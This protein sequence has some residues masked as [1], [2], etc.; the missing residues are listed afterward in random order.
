MKR[1]TVKGSVE[2]KVLE[3]LALHPDKLIKPMSKVL[4]KDYKSVHNAVENLEKKMYLEKGKLI[5][6]RGGK[7]TSYKLTPKGIACVLAMG[8]VD[9]IKVYENYTEPQERN[10]ELVEFM[11]KFRVSFGDSLF[12]NSVRAAGAMHLDV[13]E[14]QSLQDFPL[15]LAVA[16]GLVMEQ[17]SP[18]EK[19]RIVKAVKNFPRLREIWQELTKTFG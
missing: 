2:R 11:K 9:P 12:R 19:D 7:F 17:V 18:K 1:H 6:T 13:A 10:S 4:G 15:Y 14:T 3:Y 5:E 16:I 8:R